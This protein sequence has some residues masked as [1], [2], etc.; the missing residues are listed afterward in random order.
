MVDQE[1]VLLI[2]MEIVEVIHFFN[3][4]LHTHNIV[5]TV[6]IELF[7]EHMVAEEEY[8]HTRPSRRTLFTQQKDLVAE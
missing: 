4:V 1:T 8:I 5:L 3:M 2:I 6:T 7:T